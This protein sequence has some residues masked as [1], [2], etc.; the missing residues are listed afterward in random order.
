MRHSI[1]SLVLKIRRM[2]RS[3]SDRGVRNRPPVSHTS[4]YSWTNRA[5][6]RGETANHEGRIG[7]GVCNRCTVLGSRVCCAFAS[8]L[9]LLWWLPSRHRSS[10]VF[11]RVSDVLEV[12]RA[13]FSPT[14]HLVRPL[15]LS[16]S[17]SLSLSLPFPLVAEVIEGQ[18]VRSTCATRTST[19]RAF[20]SALQP[21]SALREDVTCSTPRLSRVSP[22][23]SQVRGQWRGSFAFLITSGFVACMCVDFGFNRFE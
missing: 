2:V 8:F 1:P 17:F 5:S 4:L 22:A 12:G 18:R 10:R 3:A 21:V 14:F 19:Q 20:V 9:P 23:A 15:S 7:G 11:I 13:T 16:L 6:P